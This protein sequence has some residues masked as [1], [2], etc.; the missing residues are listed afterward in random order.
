MALYPSSNLYP[1]DTLYPN[2]TLIKIYSPLKYKT[3][4]KLLENFVET[5]IFDQNLL[6]RFLA[7]DANLEYN[8]IDTFIMPDTPPTSVVNIDRLDS[9]TKIN[10]ESSLVEVDEFKSVTKLLS[11]S[12]IIDQSSDNSKIELYSNQTTVSIK[13]F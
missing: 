5:D 6:T 1:R 2:Q 12:N 4:I 11:E 3:D 8:G 13:E 7:S 9:L 10:H